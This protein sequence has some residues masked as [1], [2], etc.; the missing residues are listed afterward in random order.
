MS[1]ES[2]FRYTPE[3]EQYIFDQ[4]RKV[5][6]ASNDD[7][8]A[9]LLGIF[10][11]KLLLETGALRFDAIEDALQSQQQVQGVPYEQRIHL[12]GRHI[13]D[14]A[15]APDIIAVNPQFGD[16]PM[17][18]YPLLVIGEN[19]FNNRLK[20]EKINQ[21]QNLWRLKNAGLIKPVPGTQV[22]RKMNYMNN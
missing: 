3:L 11:E 13:N 17:N 7:Q 5:I 22:S 16:L 20:R 14:C 12:V 18:Y 2:K 6:K 1:P 10:Y 4:I 8:S 9:G 15:D 21:E 19:N